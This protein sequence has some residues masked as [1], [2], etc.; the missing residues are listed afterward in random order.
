MKKSLLFLALAHSLNA[1]DSVVTFNE[2]HYN[3]QGT[4][5]DLEW[6]E[7]HNQMAINVDFSGWKVTGGVNFTVPDGTVIPGGGYFLV[8]KDP[9]NPALT[10]LNVT[11]P[12][13]GSLANG[14]ETIRL[15]SR[16][17][18]L[19]DEVDYSDSRQ[20]PVGPDGSGATLAKIESSLLSDKSSSWRSSSQIGGTP[21]AANFP[22][23]SLP[24]PHVFV[25]SDASWKF[26]DSGSAPSA[27]WNSSNYNDNAW[28]SGQTLFGTTSGGGGPAI[29]PVTD[30]LVE[31]FRASDLNLTNGQ[32]VSSWPDTATADGQTQSAS[33]VGNPTFA[34]NATPSGEPAVRFDGNDQLRTSIAPGIGNTSGFVFF[35][36]IKA[37][38]TPG[39]GGVGN[40]SGPYIWDRDSNV[41]D[42][43]LT[44]LKSDGG[45]Y[46]LQKRYDNG[47]GLGG[48]ISSTSISTSD[49]QIVAIRRNRS[50]SQ[51][52]TWVDGVQE[53]TNNDTGAAL[54]PQPIVIGNHS[55][56][57]GGFDGD[58]AELLIYEDELTDSEFEL[59]G[60]YLESRYGLDTEFPGN[61]AAPTTEL[62]DNGSTAYLR[63]TF[64]YNGDPNNTSVRLNHLVADG[65]VVYLNGVEVQRVNM[66]DGDVSH[67]TNALSDI[68]SPISS[69]FITLPGSSLLNG[70]NVLAV[71]LHPASGNTSVSFASTLEGTETP[72][73]PSSS[74][75]LA[76][77]EVSP[78][79]VNN[80][81]VEFINPGSTPVSTSGYTLQIDGT[82]PLTIELPDA[83][84]APGE[85]LLIDHTSFPQ[86]PGS[87]DKLFL[88]S[89]SGSSLADAREVT[90]RLRGLSPDYPGQWLFPDFST[91]F[92]PNA[93]AFNTDIVVNEICYNPPILD[94]DPGVPPTVNVVPLIDSGDIWRY[95]EKGDSLPSDWASQEHAIGGNWESGPTTLAYET[96][97]DITTLTNPASNFPRVVTY[98]FETE[99]NLTAQ[100][101]ADLETLSFN[102]LID[103]GAIFYL[104][105]VELDRYQMSA[106]TVSSSTFASDSVGNAAW[107][108]EYSISIPAGAARVGSN[109]ISVEVHQQSLGSSDITFDFE[110]K[111]EFVTDPGIPATK[112]RPGSAQWIELYNR[113]T[114]D[115]NLANW[116]FGEGVDYDF[117]E[118]T[119][120]A[121]NSYL[122]I[123][124]DPA[125]LA[126]QHPS[127]TVL[128]PFE[129]SLSR[130]SETITLRDQYNNPVDT[131]RYF[132]GGR[133]PDKA[134]AQ[135][136]TIEL[137]DPN[138]DNSMPAAW[139][140][141][142]ELA[143]TSWQNYTFRATASSSPVGNDSQWREFIF[144]MLEEG[145]ILLDDLTVT[146][147]PDGS[148]V[149]MISNGT[150]SNLNTWRALGNH[151]D[152]EI[153]PDPDG[154]GSVLHLKAIGSTEHQHNHVE[155][156]LANNRSITNGREY[157]VSFRARWL[158]GSH[159]L[160]TRLYFNRIPHTFHLERPD[161][162]G[163]PGAA[164][165]TLVANAGPS[166]EN[167]S[168]SPAVPAAGESVTINADVFDTD[169]ID[170]LTLNYR[171]E[172]GAFASV[173]MAR[174]GATPKWEGAIPGQSAGNVVQFYLTATD[175]L[176]A[177]TFIPADGPDSRAMYEVEDG[178]A[179]TT[180]CINNFRIVMDPADLTWMFT[181]RNLMSNGRVPCTVIDR[182]GKAYYNAGVRIKGSQRARGQRNRVGFN[183]GFPS[184]Q[185][186][187]NTHRSVAID[188]SEGQVVG[189]RELLFD[190]MATSSGGVPGEF[191]DLAYV[192]SPNPIHTSAAILQMARFGSVFL[193]DQFEDGSDGTVYEYE[194]V[195]YPTTTDA[196]GYKVPEPDRVVGR[197]IN[198]MGDDPEAYRWTYLIK[199][200]QE[201]DDYQPAMAL[202]KQFSKSTADFN[203]SVA[204]V[205]DVDQWLRALAYSCASGAG[206]SFYTN[207][208]HNGQFYGRPDGKILY[209]PH[210]IDFSFNATRGIFENSEL[211]RIVANQ[212]Y[213]RAYLAHLY[214]ICTTVYNRSWMAPWTA[215]FDECVPGGNVFSDD[216][217]YINSRSNYIL[218]QVRSQV[219]QVSFAITTNGGNNFSTMDSPVI[220]DG[221]GWVDVK[222]IRLSNGTVLDT[223]WT[224]TDDW[225][226]PLTLGIGTNVIRLEAF[227]SQGDSVGSDNI[228]ITR[229]G[230]P[231]IPGPDTLVVSEIFYNPSGQGEGTEFIELLNVG[232][233]S[234][235]L[236]GSR[237]TDGI[238]FTFPESTTL[239]PGGRILI[240]GNRTAF[241]ARYGVGLPITGEFENG[242]VLSNGGELIT[243]QNN[244]GTVIQSFTYDDNAPWPEAA[245][246]DDFSLILLNPASLPDHNLPTNWRASASFGGNPGSE[247]ACPP[248]VGDTTADNDLDGIPA[249]IEYY[250][251]TSDSTYG[252]AQS[253]LEYGTIIGAGQI[254]P[255]YTVTHKV[256][257]DIVE[258][259][260]Q[261]SLN[262]ED[263]S[264]LT[265]DIVPHEQVS[266]GDGTATS[267]WRSTRPLETTPRQFFRLR[268]VIE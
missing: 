145:E 40:G 188:R 5:E 120:L 70:S 172:G 192:I 135:G 171:V 16:S 210:D 29:L 255:S 186:F 233:G 24:I 18:R 234:L 198:N 189:Q 181:P 132:D 12:F 90:N 265:I 89:S 156:T 80:F 57:N 200:N 167:L 224:T 91:P 98:Y 112:S 43:P 42:S 4:A 227:D 27:N 109:R 169:G 267:T 52:E 6:I 153:I 11:G 32:I 30:H 206:D 240:V 53:A 178:R 146:E 217:S 173:P 78:A 61:G 36:V 177:A 119:T 77:N 149:A 218:N 33:S 175:S 182:E 79:G 35:A 85:L 87:G 268:A 226:I 152:V 258:A 13:T 211:N 143:R 163:T 190:L 86:I 232:D 125:T 159:L 115:V 157:E 245:D 220:L 170:T 236:G 239:A 111:A 102:H 150:F 72:P 23:A 121:A 242:T 238:D 122:V 106:G 225:Q 37:N 128:G 202:G 144:G 176:G 221:R 110:A 222:E 17:E 141:S 259:S 244:T 203:T 241:E 250:L 67:G 205:L 215:H 59:V 193:E 73:D 103:D 257:A 117:P 230:G 252:D 55:D 216:L 243:L 63:Q 68:A 8:A 26:E 140:A 34:A 94:A 105:G 213:R 160:H 107:I 113:G 108:G 162:F 38:S 133:W 165:S 231:D 180:D 82:S 137:I 45:R 196:G 124:N 114:Q 19:M 50:D 130:R 15:R 142:D 54:T 195:Y 208:N 201:F 62:D 56:G 235:E 49:Y 3:P 66:P 76:L 212:A 22:S 71:S 184:D 237:F 46:A 126:S 64:T 100:E 194:L 246:G 9:S 44:S 228:T 118:G 161:I 155:A 116:D 262:L 223:T 104:N 249:L 168:H 58:I 21:G 191:N 10:G 96:G 31:R 185:L 138:A 20:W 81:F 254:F 261:I 14:G 174:V 197:D 47:S 166:S 264:N 207:S 229:T 84:L 134:D 219:P 131:L 41:S 251:G 199:N 266:N 28:A 2:I 95:N 127:I 65:A 151:R 187:R 154:G 204:D 92:S 97:L 48:P 74:S 148:A 7:V 93:F 60:A 260:A 183:V 75:G 263:W 129:G 51:F 1:S 101:V 39:N 25:A 158:S 83:T 136:S 256:G 179:A 164:N 253:N 69:G 147:N 123:S 139:A 247:D 88:Y 209:F 248:F 99:F 214:D